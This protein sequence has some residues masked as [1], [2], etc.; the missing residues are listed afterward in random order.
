VLF[1]GD[2]DAPTTAGAG[3]GIGSDLSSRSSSSSNSNSSSVSVSD[4][5]LLINHSWVVTAVKL[6]IILDLIFTLPLVMLVA[7]RAIEQESSVPQKLAAWYWHQFGAPATYMHV[8]SDARTDTASAPAHALGDIAPMPAY[9]Y[10]YVLRTLRV[11]LVL[12]AVTLA[13][14]V[15]NFASLMTIIGG[16]TC[17][18]VGFILPPLLYIAAWGDVHVGTD[19]AGI[20]IRSRMY[21]WR[22]AV[23]RSEG[24][25]LALSLVVSAVCVFCLPAHALRTISPHTRAESLHQ[26]LPTL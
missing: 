17:V 11:I 1:Y 23:Q 8:Q 5:L 12:F 13:I 21:Q 20:S 9:I 4:V 26:P 18:S 7:R 3:L 10:T 15:P 14:S 25:G 22:N 16:V 2:Y 19:T 6:L 24:C